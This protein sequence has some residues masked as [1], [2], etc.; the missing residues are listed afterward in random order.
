MPPKKGS[1]KKV[2]E[3]DP[4]VAEAEAKRKNMIKEADALKKHIDFEEEE[5][6]RMQLSKTRLMHN[7]V[8]LNH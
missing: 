6:R 3:V 7:W 8:S 1:K 5:E 2:E 4:A